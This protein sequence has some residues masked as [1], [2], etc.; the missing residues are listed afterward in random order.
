V[1]FRPIGHGVRSTRSFTAPLEET[2]YRMRVRLTAETYDVV[3]RIPGRAAP[4]ATVR[5]ELSRGLNWWLVA[6]LGVAALALAGIASVVI[7]RRRRIAA[8]L[9]QADR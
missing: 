2:V 7:R 8:I 4:V 6:S 3:V 1:E 5:L 9:T